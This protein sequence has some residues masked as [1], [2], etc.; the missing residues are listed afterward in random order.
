MPF[1]HRKQP[2]LPKRHYVKRQLR[3]TIYGVAVLATALLI[4]IIGYMTFADLSL[5]DAF[6]NASMILAGMGPVDPMLTDAAKVF[7]SCYAL[8]SGV[9]FLSTIAVLLAPAIHRLM[10]KLHIDADS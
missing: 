7:A 8:L 4:G 10:H 2:L 9:A 6:H 3:Y 1:E 5:L